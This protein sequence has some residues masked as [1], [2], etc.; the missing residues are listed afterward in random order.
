MIGCTF[1]GI[2]AHGCGGAA[3]N[4]Q[5][6]A[7]DITVGKIVAID[8]SSAVIAKNTRGLRMGEIIHKP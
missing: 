3:L 1:E 4:I 7:E 5:G 8:T 6:Y 2:E